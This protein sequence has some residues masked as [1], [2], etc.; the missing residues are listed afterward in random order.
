M[1]F[2]QQIQFFLEEQYGARTGLNVSDFVRITPK[3]DDLGKL[4]VEQDPSSND[5]NLALL[6]DRDIYAAYDNSKPSSSNNSYRWMS[7]SFEEVSHFVYLS[8]N[9]NRGRNITSLELELQSEVD[10]I[11]LAFHSGLT[12]D[13][14]K[15]SALLNELYNNSYSQDS[16]YETARQFAASFV[17]Q[18][19]SEV[20]GNDPRAWTPLEFNKLRKFFHSDLS[21][22][23]HLSRPK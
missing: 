3:L 20:S 11:L 21:E 17:F 18:L 15:H 4:I 10:R 13:R 12:Q 9:H 16:H 8:Y 2:L 23:I 1:K 14:I 7:V 22:K 19:C 6:L 5:I